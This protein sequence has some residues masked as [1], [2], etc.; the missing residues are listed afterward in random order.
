LRVQGHEAK[1]A[2][3]GARGVL[4]AAG[5]GR[6]GGGGAKRV[7]GGQVSV[8]VYTVGL[9]GRL[10]G[11]H[12]LVR[13]RVSGAGLGIGISMLDQCGRLG[14]EKI[15]GTKEWARGGGGAGGRRWGEGGRGGE[16]RGC[17]CIEL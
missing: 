15:R 10:W 6:G 1:M 2:G 8:C 11:G 7:G 17:E 4:M 13:G 16:W 9:Q 14:R 3:R 12:T 5:W